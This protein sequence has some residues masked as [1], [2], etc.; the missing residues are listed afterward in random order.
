MEAQQHHHQW[1]HGEQLHGHS[2]GQ[3]HSGGYQW[4]V[5]SD[6]GWCYGHGEHTP[7]RQPHSGRVYQYLFGRERGTEREYRNRLYLCMEAERD[8]DQRRHEQQLH[9]DPGR[10]PYGNRDQWRLLHHFFRSERDSRERHGNGFAY[11]GWGYDVLLGRQRALV[12]EHGHRPELC[13]EALR[14]HDQ[15]RHGQQLHGE[16][17]R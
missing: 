16:P 15:W 14:H 12:G 17:E 1:C 2:G 8:H 11:G 9:R 3:L 7:D 6:L 10:K 5:F 4:D 13:L